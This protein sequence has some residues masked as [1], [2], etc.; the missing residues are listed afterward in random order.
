MS[1]IFAYLRF[2]LFSFPRDILDSW[3]VVVIVVIT[4]GCYSC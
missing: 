1:Y 4:L 3:L 2:V